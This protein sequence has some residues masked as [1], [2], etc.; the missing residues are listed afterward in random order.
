MEKYVEKELNLDEEI[1]HG[2][3][4][5]KRNFKEGIGPG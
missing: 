3:K 4:F 2:Y 1:H 5:V